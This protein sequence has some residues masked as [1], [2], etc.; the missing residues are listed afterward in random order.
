M[1]R[2]V[3]LTVLLVSIVFLL[4]TYAGKPVKEPSGLKVWDSQGELLGMLMRHEG[5]AGIQIFIPDMGNFIDAMKY[6]FNKVIVEIKYQTSDC[7]GPMFVAFG[8]TDHLVYDNAA[9]KTYLV[10]PPETVTILSEKILAT[11]EC[12]SDS[13]D[14][15]LSP[16]TGVAPEDVTIPLPLQFPITYGY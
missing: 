4:P 6:E 15:L 9:D 16:L 1:K 11:G 12:R 10:M 5:T 2:I 8:Y 3:F 14:V 13:R 7:T